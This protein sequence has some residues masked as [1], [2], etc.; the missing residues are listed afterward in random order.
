MGIEK[1]ATCSVLADVAQ[2]VRSEGAIIIVI[3]ALVAHDVTSK[4]TAEIVLHRRLP[5]R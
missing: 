1:L 3:V 4:V 2:L 5:R